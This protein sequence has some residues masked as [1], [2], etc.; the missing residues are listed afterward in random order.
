MHECVKLFG[1][2]LHECALLCHFKLR[3]LLGHSYYDVYSLGMMDPDRG[4]SSKSDKNNISWLA[5]GHIINYGR[6]GAKE[7]GKCY[8]RNFA[9]PLSN[10]YLIL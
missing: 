9:I 10:R 2:P 8:P 5:E 4:F 7:S 1:S 3:L 6:G